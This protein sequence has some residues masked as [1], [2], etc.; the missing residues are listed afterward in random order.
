[1]PISLR[2]FVDDAIR[3]HGPSTV[4]EIAEFARAAGATRARNPASAVR[5]TLSQSSVAIPLPDGRWSCPAWVLD[6]VVLT[7]RARSSTAGR[8]DLWPRN[9]LFPFL[10]LME[11]GVPVTSGGLVAFAAL[12]RQ[13]SPVLVGP[14]GWLPPVEAGG[15][16]ALAWR[17]GQLEVTPV[18]VD[19]DDVASRVETLRDSFVYHRD[20]NTLYRWQ[21]PF[22]SAVLAT[23]LEVPGVLSTP[24]PPLGE[25]LG[26]LLR[27][28]EL[29]RR[30]PVC[31]WHRATDRGH[32]DGSEFAPSPSAAWDD[33]VVRPLFM[34]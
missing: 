33:P 2:S 13:R 19:A 17:G 29:A 8:R 10:P 15:L 24:L 16:L 1:M 21:S 14:H 28:P 7:H 3:T 6:G 5:T 27:P 31:C 25:I 22:A 30:Q 34:S 20:A 4:E 23:V 26:D 32:D 18:E 12:H 11:A 9:D